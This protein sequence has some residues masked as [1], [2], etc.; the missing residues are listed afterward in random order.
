MY[1]FYIRINSKSIKDLNIKMN[2]QMHCKKIWVN[3]LLTLVQKGLFNCH[4]KLRS[5]KILINL[6]NQKFKTTTWQNI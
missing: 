5:H 1:L 6:S 2:A 4:L 3:F